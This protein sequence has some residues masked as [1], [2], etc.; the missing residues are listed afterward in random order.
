MTTVE[1]GRELL[2]DASLVQLMS[3]ATARQP[4]PC[5]ERRDAGRTI[6]LK[7]G[8]PLEVSYEPTGRTIQTPTRGPVTERVQRKVQSDAAR[9]RRDQSREAHLR[10]LL[11][12]R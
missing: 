8:P 7:K 4:H 3:R 9:E 10:S 6:S 5:A 11:S 1:V 12:G 2:L